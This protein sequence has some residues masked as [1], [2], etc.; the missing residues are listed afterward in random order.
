MD[1]MAAAAGVDPLEFRLAHLDDPR[2]RPVL[3]EAAKRFKWT[4]RVK[5]K[6]PNRGVGLACSLD[7]GSYVACC[8]E[9]ELD[10]AAGKIRVLDVCQVFDCGPVMN[11]D[12]LRNQM[13]G[14]IIMGL[15]PALSEEMKFADGEIKSTS[16]ASY[17]VPHFKDVPTIETHAM[18]RK[19]VDA[20]G[21]GE[22]PIIA[23]AP[24]IGNAVYHASAVRVRS[25]PMR[26]PKG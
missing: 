21:A 23:I 3:E 26:L 19:D 25:M 10:R 18:D 24:A 1:E 14:A 7:K 11:P 9:V 2:L 6:Q 5:N 22:T 12:N 17:R 8:A 4:E 15:G 13:E 20:A 16:F